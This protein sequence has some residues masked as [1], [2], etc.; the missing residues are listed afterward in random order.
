MVNLQGAAAVTV[1]DASDLSAAERQRLK[2]AT[3]ANVLVVPPP[4]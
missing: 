1:A 4:A 2:A 3:K